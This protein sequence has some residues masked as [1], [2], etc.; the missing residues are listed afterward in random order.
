MSKLNQE[1]QKLSLAELEAKIT[2]LR[3]DLVEQQRA[4][5]A[6]ELPNPHAVRA[7]RRK[8]AIALTL[9]NNAHKTDVS[10]KEEGKEA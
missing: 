10:N 9:I 1:L 4:L 8:I 6:G 2:D 3:V 7:T 5:A